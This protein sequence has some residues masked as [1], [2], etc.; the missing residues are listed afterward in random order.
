MLDFVK[1]RSKT[2]SNINYIYPEFQVRK[3]TKDL[4][5]RGKSFYAVWD[6]ENGLW[7]KDEYT[8]GQ[9]IDQMIADEVEK[10]S[11]HGICTGLYL[12]D[13]S[14]NM[15]NTWQKYVKSLPDNYHELDTTI[16][17]SNTEVDKE[18]YVS[19]RLSY[20]I[21][22]METP[23][24]DKLM[25]TLY[26][27]DQ[28]E[29]IE[30]AIGAVISG[31]SKWIQKFLVF[32]GAAGTG[33]STVLN[34]IQML[35][36]GYYNVFEAKALGNGN[37]AFALEPF[38]DNPLVAIQ[39]DGD[40]SR[41]ED[42]TRL[43]SII[44]H[45]KLVMNEKFKSQYT[46]QF[47][48]FLFM[49]TNEPVKITGSKSGMLRRL[50]DV[51]PSNKKLPL[52]EYNSCMKKIIF[53]LGGIAQHCLDLYEEYGPGYFDN[54]VPIDMIG[55][56]ND[57][58]DFVEYHFEE[59]SENDTIT[60]ATAWKQYKEYCEFANVYRPLVYRNFREELKDYFKEYDNKVYS[61]FKKEKFQHKELV[62]DKKDANDDIWIDFNTRA[63]IFDITEAEAPAQYASESSGKPFIKWDE[64]TTK[65]SD[66]DTSRLHYVN[67]PENHIVIDFDIKD[68][69]GNKDLAANL[70]AASK[71][72][73]TYAEI[74]KSGAGIHLHY[75][76]DGDVSKLSSVYEPEI[77]IKVFSGNQSL[78]RQ[79]TKCNDI[80]IATISSGLP[81][82]KEKKKV[83]KE[84]TLK[85]EK[86]LRTF[87]YR[88]LR[89]EYLPSTVQSCGFIYD[90]LKK[91][92]DSGMHY[93]ISDLQRLC[94]EF[95]GHATNQKDRS[96]R[97]I[98]DAP[99]KSDE[100]SMDVPFDDDGKICFF[101]VEVFPNLFVIVY[102]FI[103][104]PCQILINPSPDD[105]ERLTHY[106]LI[107][108]NNRKYDNHILYARIMGYS[109]KGLYE[110]SQ[111]IIVYKKSFFNEAYN[112]AYS[113]I[114]DFA[115]VKQSLKK[116]EIALG[117]N[118]KE[119]N[120]PWDQPVPENLWEEVAMYCCNDVEATEAVFNACSEDWK[121]RL[122]MCKL[123]GLT[124]AHT[125]RQLITKFLL[126]DDDHIDHVYTDLSKIF[127]G[128]EFNPDGFPIE[129]YEVKPEGSTRM[130]KSYYMGED[131]SEGGYVYS[132]PGM[133]SN[134]KTYDIAGMHPASLIALN[135]F[136]EKTKIFEALRDMRIMIKHEDLESARKAL[137][138]QFAEYLTDI[139]EAKAL[140]K[141]LKLILNSTYGLVAASFDNPLADPRDVD[142]II[143]KRG[144]LFMITLKNE[145]IKRGYKVIHCKTDSI[146]VVDPDEEIENFIFDFGKKYGYD[147]EIESV[148]DKICLINRAV[149]IA[150]EHTH[151]WE[152]TGAQFAIPYVF[153]T[154]FSGE[155]VIFSDL[156]EVK[157]VTSGAMYLDF[158]EAN[159]EEHHRQFIGRVSSF[160]PIKPGC[161]GGLLVREQGDKFNAVTGTKGY[162]WMEFSTVMSLPKKEDIVDWSYYNTLVDSAKAALSKFGDVESFLDTFPF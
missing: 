84:E 161:G 109:L 22:A 115:T 96:I 137:N 132:V 39:H 61:M 38:K 45:E 126:G 46:M 25:S 67:L 56:T 125:N 94:V 87:V 104:E 33:K 91:A 15:W 145:V 100:P 138:G 40:L 142:N 119:L 120:I 105:C 98:M 88:S 122:L 124:P 32:Y 55:A 128:Y 103:G 75:I 123:T 13:Y 30:W 89:K 111:D 23:N 59:Y 50:I 9:L 43:N 152:A 148:F 27:P 16:T 101:D 12:A 4:M 48:S 68:K 47:H 107:G 130:H 141:A 18:D 118:H 60:L 95:A 37:A 51:H 65:L 139:H 73:K 34:I 151:G 129:K 143:A 156:Q 146:K 31:D 29:K 1:I 6:E 42:N 76:Y 112:L 78:R 158:N 135:K 20:P 113:D 150:Y 93:D 44:S 153:K 162:R 14:S 117:I 11:R 85:N 114:F 28:R 52:R 3:R 70:R 66:I 72:P 41:I 86:A 5:I 58:Y 57:F 131:P 133:Y 149:Y 17:F 69:D 49:G 99:F 144:A 2:K 106:K 97:Y 64:V 147:F 82:R 53:E 116:W 24:Y 102:K 127:P 26:S 108:F 7:S 80:P 35:F 74:S 62:K 54:Y 134:V 157:S 136:G 159:E 140:A 92:Y 79:L 81:F 8:V 90:T 154:L 110:L 77:E 121:V 19:R 71:F 83:L 36:D 10:Q 63:S 160:I 155:K 21:K